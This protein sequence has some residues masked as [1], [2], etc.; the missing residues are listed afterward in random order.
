MA[1]LVTFPE[2]WRTIQNGNR[3]PRDPILGRLQIVYYFTVRPENV[4]VKVRPKLLGTEV[5]GPLSSVSLS[6]KEGASYG[7]VSSVLGCIRNRQMIIR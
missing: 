7:P 6:P 1:G 5:A 2:T 3:R 4:G